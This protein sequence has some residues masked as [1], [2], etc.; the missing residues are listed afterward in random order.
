MIRPL[1]VHKTSLIGKR[2]T[3]E[4][5]EVCVLGLGRM[6]EPILEG[7]GPIDLLMIC[8]GHGGREVAEF[9][10]ARLEKR[11]TNPRL[12]YPLRYHDVSEIYDTIQNELV[13]HPQKIAQNCGC[14]ALVV[15]RF[16]GANNKEYLQI[17]NLGDCRAVI[18]SQGIGS[19]LCKDHKPFWS[20]E[21]KRIENVN[22]RLNTQNRIWKDDHG[23]WRI[24][25]LSVSRSFGDILETPYVSHLPDSFVRE[26]TRKDDFIIM[27][28]D[29]LW[30]V[31]SNGEA[32]GFVKDHIE[33]NDISFY[34]IPG[35]YP[36][37]RS[38][39][40]IKI[41]HKLADYA[42]ANGS[43]DNVSI[44]IIYLKEFF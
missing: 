5:V 40:D 3:N 13:N 2:P 28:C 20:D 25:E 31:I 33:N 18:C 16:R 32:V 38:S 29:G 42:I 14:T 17:I 10:S 12:R 37:P 21:R 22:K 6:G 26:I 11:L 34:N 43:T 15:I 9:V 7:K 8:D 1:T 44:M 19:P 24:G 36:D 39:K 4:D 30:D 27:G 35:V 41:A 23:E